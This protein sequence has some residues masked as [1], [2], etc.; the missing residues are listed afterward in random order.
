M[1]KVPLRLAVYE[2]GALQ[3]HPLRP[4][5]FVYDPAHDDA[6]G[7]QRIVSFGSVVLDCIQRFGSSADGR[8]AADA[9]CAQ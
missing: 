4:P 2:A 5:Q 1:V 8:A 7:R 6:S 9:A 3:S